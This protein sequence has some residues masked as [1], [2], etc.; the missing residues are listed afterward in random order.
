MAAQRAFHEVLFEKTIRLL[1]E[2]AVLAGRQARPFAR[3]AEQ[4]LRPERLE[5]AK[6][7]LE[8]GRESLGTALAKIAAL[9]S[10]ISSNVA[11]KNRWDFSA[12][13][14]I[15]EWLTQELMRSG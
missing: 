9:F 14:E 12:H 13:T 2:E 4:W 7:P 15:R 10:D 11:H 8:P 5:A 6:I 1:E 3:R